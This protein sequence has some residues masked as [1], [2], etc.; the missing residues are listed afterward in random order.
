MRLLLLRFSPI[1]VVAIP[2]GVRK[3][4]LLEFLVGLADDDANVGLKGLSLLNY[5]LSK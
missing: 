2:V 1:D 5:C 4:R 3:G